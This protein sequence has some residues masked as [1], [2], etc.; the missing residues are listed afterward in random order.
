M[1]G[2]RSEKMQLEIWH[3]KCDI[4]IQFEIRIKIPTIQIPLIQI[5]SNVTRG[6]KQ[7]LG[8][9]QKQLQSVVVQ[10][11]SKGLRVYCSAAP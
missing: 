10:V 9:C 2:E 6:R 3:E 8:T 4:A 5:R 11:T 7:R 1:C